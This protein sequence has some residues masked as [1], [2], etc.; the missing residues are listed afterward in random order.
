MLH[1]ES[2][3]RL[4][5]VNQMFKDPITRFVSRAIDVRWHHNKIIPFSM[6]GF[7]P[8]EG[9]IFYP[10][11][12]P[13]AEWLKEPT[14]SVRRWNCRDRLMFGLLFAVHDYLHVWGTRLIQELAPAL[15]FGTSRI[16]RDN[17]EEHVFCQL[18]SEAIATVGLDYWYLCTFDINDRLP[19]GTRLTGGLTTT[20]QE[21]HLDEFRRANPKLCV[22]CQEFFV[23][24]CH[25]YCSGVFFGFEA[26]DIKESP[27][28]YGWLSR[29]LAY[30][31]LQRKISRS[32]FSYLSDETIELTEK[33]LAAP[34]YSGAS[35]QRELMEAAGSALW[36]KVK[37]D[38]LLAFPPSAEP[39]W[40]SLPGKALDF[41]FRNA[42]VVS[43]EELWSSL[44]DTDQEQFDY[45]FSQIISRYDH[46]AFDK[47]LLGLLSLLREKKDAALLRAVLRGQ[48]RMP[49]DGQEPADLLLVN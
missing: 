49:M 44:L 25:F 40:Q 8:F 33:Q 32:W 36:R 42:N 18:V 48:P 5:L 30:G 27:L 41:R 15:R 3:L 37:Q 4:S 28:L 12:S 34:V 10:R 13:F 23:D 31:E 21:R 26:T 1:S 39:P 11:N 29:E 9:N 2:P 43:E 22:Q 47:A 24:L 7:N 20:Y 19:V 16:T 35:W 45:G 38:E 17:L 14:S 46:A 6:T